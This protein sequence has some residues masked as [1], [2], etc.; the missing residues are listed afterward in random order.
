MKEKF[1]GRF[2]YLSLTKICPSLKLEGSLIYNE[3]ARFR[4]YSGN[5]HTSALRAE[6]KRLFKQVLNPSS[7]PHLVVAKRTPSAS[8][9]RVNNYFMDRA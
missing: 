9:P 2:D 5:L 4:A 7:P 1:T 8:N 3:I 6:L